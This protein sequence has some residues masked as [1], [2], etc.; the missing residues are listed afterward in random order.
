ME[1]PQTVT[2]P[3]AMHIGAPARPVVQVGDEVKAGDP[4]AVIE[5]MKMET[6]I[7][8]PQDGVIATVV[9]SQGASVQTDEVL[10]TMN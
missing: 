3:M 6:E 9:A 1:F 5:A 2:I 4:V 7:P 10:M 8:A